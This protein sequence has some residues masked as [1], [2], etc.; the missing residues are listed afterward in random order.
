MTIDPFND[1]QLRKLCS[2]I[3]DTGTGLT[4]TEISNLLKT[5]GITDPAPSLSKRERLFEAL[6]ARQAQDRCGNNIVNFFQIA[7]D[8]VRYS[9]ETEKFETRRS[10]L[11]LVLILCGYEI[12]NDGKFRQEKAVN[13]LSEAEERAGRLR[14]E[15]KRRGVHHDVLE[16][17]RGELLQENYFHAVLEAT[18][19]VGEKIR[20]ISGLTADGSK[21]IDQAFGSGAAGMP[22]IAFNSQQTE[23]EQNEHNGMMHLMKGMFS[24]FRNVTAHA[25]K[26][27]WKI[28]EQDALDLLTIVSLLHRRLDGATRTQRIHEKNHL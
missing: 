17:C 11:N 5:C 27:S 6:S 9:G 20:K 13:T 1:N 12:G 23:S 28:S 22:F 7:M 18:K 3:A 15:L 24:A 16:F 14:A 8:P 2:V 25:P 4:G 21:L 10:E 26:I 19:S